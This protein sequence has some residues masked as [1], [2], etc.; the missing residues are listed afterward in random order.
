MK[1]DSAAGPSRRFVPFWC[2]KASEPRAPCLGGI[3]HCKAWRRFPTLS[4]IANAN[5]LDDGP[6]DVVIGAV[7]GHAVV[8]AD[9]EVAGGDLLKTDEYARLALVAGEEDGGLVL[10]DGGR[11]GEGGGSV[12]VI[13]MRG[14]EGLWHVLAGAAAEE[15]EGENQEERS[16][17]GQNF[18]NDAIRQQEDRCSDKAAANG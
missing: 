10:G 18:K 11:K 9:V 7:V 14:A 15:G 3:S 2:P 13:R 17:C 6:A 5:L 12:L 16:H 1:F 4:T 8:G